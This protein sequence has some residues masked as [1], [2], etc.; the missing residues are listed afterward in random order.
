MLEEVTPPEEASVITQKDSGYVENTPSSNAAIS[1]PQN[2]GLEATPLKK[3][4][5]FTDTDAERINKHPLTPV[6]ATSLQIVAGVGRV[7]EAELELTS[8]NVN[9]QPY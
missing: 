6:N 5:R 3:R 4:S 1:M 9:A 8:V 2:T 7:I